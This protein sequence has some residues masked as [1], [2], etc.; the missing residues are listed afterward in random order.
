MYS[1]AGQEQLGSERFA[2]STIS[3]SSQFQARRSEHS[4]RSSSHLGLRYCP[5]PESSPVNYDHHLAVPSA[6]SSARPR[7]SALHN[8][9]GSRDNSPR[10]GYRIGVGET[11]PER[12]QPLRFGN[13]VNGLYSPDSPFGATPAAQASCAIE[14]SSAW[15][16]DSDLELKERAMQRR[17]HWGSL[18]ASW[19]AKNAFEA[20][21]S[22][23]EPKKKAAE[24]R[25]TAATQQA[26]IRDLEVL[27][28][29]A[30]L[31]TRI[32]VRN[33]M[34]WC[35]Q[36]HVLQTEVDLL[37]R[38]AFHCFIVAVKASS[39]ERALFL[40]EKLR[41]Q[42]AFYTAQ[43][44]EFRERHT[45]E[46]D[47]W[48]RSEATLE[49]DWL[50][51]WHAQSV[52]S[53]ARV[54]SL[55]SVAAAAA[56]SKDVAHAFA[57]WARASQRARL[58]QSTAWIRRA[59]AVNA[60]RVHCHR[61]LGEVF[62][63]WSR[64]YWL[65]LLA[66]ELARERDR[67]IGADVE[68]QSVY[69]CVQFLRDMWLRGKHRSLKRLPAFVFGSWVR[70]TADR[71]R[72]A[73]GGTQCD[74]ALRM[75][76][77]RNAMAMVFQ[78]WTCMC[79][80]DLKDRRTRDAM[81]R[82]RDLAIETTAGNRPCLD[83]V[84]NIHMCLVGWLTESRKSKDRRTRDAMCRTRGLAIE[85][86]ARNRPCPDLVFARRCLSL[87]FTE[88]KNS[89]LIKK[90]YRTRDLA[91]N[92]V[93]RAV[94]AC[95][96]FVWPHACL[97]HWS[98]YS[99]ADRHAR[100][101]E[102]ARQARVR[103][104]AAVWKGGVDALRSHSFWAWA[105][106]NALKKDHRQLQQE[107]TKM[108]NDN[109]NKMMGLMCMA[110]KTISVKVCFVGWTRVC[111]RPK[112]CSRSTPVVATFCRIDRTALLRHV[113]AAWRHYVD[114]HWRLRRH[115]AAITHMMEKNIKEWVRQEAM[116][117]TKVTFK[118][119]KDT[120][121]EALLEERRRREEEKAREI[122]RQL[123]ELQDAEAKLT[124]L[125]PVDTSLTSPR[126]PRT[127]LLPPIAEG[128][129]DSNDSK[130]INSTTMM[131]TTMNRIHHSSTTTKETNTH[132]TS[133]KDSSPQSP[134]A[135][136]HMLIF[137]LDYKKTENPLTCTV[138]G[139]N[140]V[141]LGRNCKSVMCETVYDDRATLM[142][143]RSKIVEV[144]TKCGPNDCFVFYYSGHGTSLADDNGDEAD[145]KDEAFCFIDQDG[146][147][148]AETCLR[149]DELTTLITQNVHQETRIII[150]ADCCHSG[151]IADMDDKAWEGFRAVSISG[152]TDKQTSVDTGHGGICTLSLLLAI[153]K[154][155]R[156][157]NEGYSVGALFKEAKQLIQ[158]DPRLN[159]EQSITLQSAPGVT[160]NSVAWPLIPSAAYSAPLN[161]GDGAAH[162]RDIDLHL[163]P[164]ANARESDKHSVQTLMTRLQGPVS[165]GTKTLPVE[166][167][168]GFYVGDYVRIGGERHVIAAFGSIV[169]R[170]PLRHSYPK[171]TP[172]VKVELEVENSSRSTV[173]QLADIL[174]NAS[175][176]LVLHQV[177]AS[178][179]RQA[180]E[181]VRESNRQLQTTGKSS[182]DMLE[183]WKRC[184]QIDE[185]HYDK[186]SR[187]HSAHMDNLERLEKEQLTPRDDWLEEWRR[188]ANLSKLELKRVRGHIDNMRKEM[189]AEQSRARSLEKKVKETRDHYHEANFKQAVSI[190]C[191]FEKTHMVRLCFSSW[192]ELVDEGRRTLLNEFLEKRAKAAEQRATVA[193]ERRKKGVLV[194][195]MA[196]QDPVL[197][198]L[199]LRSWIHA[200]QNNLR[201]EREKVGKAEAEGSLGKAVATLHRFREF[202]LG[203][204]RAQ[205]LMHYALV[206]WSRVVERGSLANQKQAVLEAAEQEHAR[207]DEYRGHV[208]QRTAEILLGSRTK[209]S[210]S[211]VFQHWT[212][213]SLLRRR[214][215]DLQNE[216]QRMGQ[217]QLDSS[218]ALIES[219]RL[220]AQRESEKASL[221]ASVELERTKIS[222]FRQQL[223]QA[224]LIALQGGHQ[225]VSLKNCI[226]VWSS[227]LG[228]SRTR[229][230]AEDASQQ[231]DQAKNTFK[232]AKA[233]VPRAV[234]AML[235][236]AMLL[237][238][239]KWLSVQQVLAHWK[240]TVMDRVWNSFVESRHRQAYKHLGTWLHMHQE[241]Q[242]LSESFLSWRRLCFVPPEL[243]ISPIAASDTTFDSSLKNRRL[244]QSS[245]ENESSLPTNASSPELDS[246]ASFGMAP[247]KWN[248]A[249]AT[250][251]TLANAHQSAQ[252]CASIDSVTRL[253]QLRQH[254]SAQD[255]LG[256][257]GESLQQMQ[258]QR[259]ADPESIDDPSVLLA[260]RLNATDNL[261][262]GSPSIQWRS[263]QEGPIVALFDGGL[264]RPTMVRPALDFT[265]DARTK[266]TRPLPNGTSLQST[267]TASPNSPRQ[268]ETAIPGKP[269]PVVASYRLNNAAAISAV[270]QPTMVRSW[271]GPQITLAGQATPKQTPA[272]APS[273]AKSCPHA[274]PRIAALAAQLGNQRSAIVTST[275]T[276]RMP[277]PASIVAPMTTSGA[278]HQAQ[279]L[280]ARQS[281]VHQTA[282]IENGR[283]PRLVLRQLSGSASVAPG[284]MPLQV[285]L[286]AA[287]QAHVQHSVVSASHRGWSQ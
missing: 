141:D 263:P 38:K 154:L 43:L 28:A 103:Q 179:L 111:M 51:R 80:S 132:T 181:R 169:L 150:L 252:A 282:N 119:W 219:Q 61:S 159:S 149:D 270:N 162:T 217:Q 23:V 98:K 161:R 262:V 189:A 35:L 68:R 167:T 186:E 160:E 14:A 221:L 233:K 42:D 93:D 33:A 24:V 192:R 116:D 152:C 203:R 143:A 102:V 171:G 180:R 285:A 214:A 136:V 283:S 174:A 108:R 18:E 29:H 115:V 211:E 125:Q 279:Q 235:R 54:Y 207:L 48:Q 52:A 145:H 134:F 188:E 265:F 230:I 94:D 31:A 100:S 8:A 59:A 63:A 245:L 201:T 60:S 128:N 19:I 260:R 15:S 248:V 25:W 276:A 106:V 229:D 286:N 97:L 193:R 287:P 242:L 99:K 91:L 37:L 269:S 206:Q 231:L 138:D 178:W 246:Q 123:K 218:T 146:Q 17:Q 56:A 5:S 166:T 195:L 144:A 247:S 36:V 254:Q 200:H 232:H 175:L 216:R 183:Y 187:I 49:E 64:E 226:S 118:A 238:E 164:T 275:S 239:H 225:R 259:D 173:R 163:G 142:N 139:D 77:A 55:A 129:E 227:T 4:V 158:D 101:M 2:L 209:T 124:C 197:L 110:D 274:A 57:R 73:H 87:W 12:S 40:D 267:P 172:V 215:T 185:T 264:A 268:R 234:E 114:G 3:S 240:L 71:R 133:E 244:F 208:L 88:S 194:S 243:A 70:Y 135:N 89:N 32:T 253:L 196:S 7:L 271:S 53:R 78:L 27:L 126:T 202:M 58:L 122:E 222:S 184:Q 199:C 127:S 155:Q 168:T 67:T 16:M 272:T 205:V 250:T 117:A 273:R 34:E 251:P 20:W 96:D 131:S 213:M 257:S 261:P 156:G 6:S 105:H 280:A 112:Y 148:T 84:F 170:S 109:Y 74:K 284:S 9:R 81:C 113:W 255:Q 176:K 22:L 266:D 66:R 198:E 140:M 11:P 82:T 39:Q 62:V 224:A 79:E 107:C 13:L 10:S 153:E 65:T 258:R 210:V 92:V 223:L 46:L 1:V 44:I 83:L 41:Q 278:W 220:K 72:R 86:T 26:Q 76:T 151:T 237:Y 45:E 256:R 50:R 69:A 236:N 120:W 182:Q 75:L 212:D 165:A 121:K 281:S 130:S 147:V 137:A 157:R 191:M 249:Q 241:R 21:R 190:F 90:C 228:R 85:T 30:E 177:Y 277:S 104:L 47:Q 95:P 204:S